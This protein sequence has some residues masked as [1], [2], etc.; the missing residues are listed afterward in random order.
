MS[1][2]FPFLQESRLVLAARQDLR[3]AAAAVAAAAAALAAAPPAA[4][5][6]AASARPPSL[7]MRL[8]KSRAR[9]GV[10]QMASASCTQTPA[11]KA[12]PVYSRQNEIRALSEMK[13]DAQAEKEQTKKTQRQGDGIA[14]AEEKEGGDKCN[15][16]EQ[17]EHT[18]PLWQTAAIPHP[19]LQS[20]KD[21]QGEQNPQRPAA[22][23][24]ERLRQ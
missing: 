5:E 7:S 10:S 20:L 16:E 18:H 8:P 13:P 24:Q 9:P 22:S 15:R 14:G 6:A 1:L 11:V 4:E 21:G 19:K 12:A 17:R 23:P 2:P 3:A